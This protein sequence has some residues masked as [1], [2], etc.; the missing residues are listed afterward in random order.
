MKIVSCKNTWNTS[1]TGQNTQLCHTQRQNQ[2]ESW[3]HVSVICQCDGKRVKFMTTESLKT[4]SAVSSVFIIYS[5]FFLPALAQREIIL[6]CFFFLK[7]KVTL[8]I[9][10]F[11]LVGIQNPNFTSTSYPSQGSP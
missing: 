5:L 10:L 8:V 11:R 4:K 6:C 3:I 1:R 9:P 7:A 2:W